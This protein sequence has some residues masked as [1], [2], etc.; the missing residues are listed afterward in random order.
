MAAGT[1]TDSDP[2]WYKDAIIYQLH[3]KTFFDGNDDGYGDFPG[4]VAKLD[5]IQELGV[6]CIWLLPFYPSPL[7]DDGYDIADYRG[8]HPVY[9]ERKDFRTFIREAHRRGIRVITELVV[10]HT[11]DQH[12]WFQAARHAPSGSIKRKYYVWSKTDKKF[13]NARIIFTDTEKSN[14]TWDPVANAFYWHR[15]F[16]HQPDLNFD[17]PH[18]RAAVVRIMRFW[19]DMGVDGLRL[20]AVPY[21]VE[22]EGTNCEN[23]P[24]T[25]EVVRQW[26][27]IIDE[28]Y[29][30]R[31]L[32]AEANQSPADVV[33]YFGSGDECHMAYHFPVMPRIFI[34]LH[35]E[36]RHPIT[37]IIEQTP[38]IPDICQWVIFLRNHDELSLE[39][40]TDAER[41]YMYTAYAQDPLMRIN[42]G[43]RRRL[44][45]LVQYSRR[46]IELLN[47]LLF[48]LPGTPVIYYGDEIGMGENV[49]LG[50]R[51][52]VRTP[53]QWNGDRNGGFSRALFAKLYSPP[54]MDPVTGYQTINVEEQSM[55]PS[56]L[57]HW[58]QTIIR[59]RR[60]YKV[61]GRGTIEFLKP[62]NRKVLAFYR[63]YQDQIVLVVANLS[64]YPQA[65]EL[66]L[67]SYCGVVP[68]E[69]FGLGEFP[70]IDQVP[71][72]ITLGAYSFYWFMLQPVCDV[73]HV[74]MQFKGRETAGQP[75]A[76]QTAPESPPFQPVYRVEPAGGWQSLFAGPFRQSLETEIL[77]PFIR[78]QSWFKTAAGAVESV[79]V[80][81]WFEVGESGINFVVLVQVHQDLYT[82][83]LS[84]ADGE[85]AE[86]ILTGKPGAVVARLSTSTT[87][88]TILYDAVENDDFCLSLLGTVEH[89]RTA[90]THAGKVMGTQ[91][92]VFGKSRGSD[93]ETPA[94]RR[95]RTEQSNSSVV[96]GN[97]L[98]LKL[99]R[100]LRPGTD[101]GYKVGRFLVEHTSFRGAPSVAGAIE[102]LFSESEEHYTLALLQEFIAGQGDGWTYSV[103]ELRR[104]FERA[105]AHMY[106]LDKLTREP[107]SIARMLEQEFAPEA[108]WL[109]GIYIKE[110]ATLG[111]RTGE[112]H[113]ALAAGTDDPDFATGTYSRAELNEFVDSLKRR[114][115][116]VMQTLQLGRTVE[117]Q[118]E[119]LAELFTLRARLLD[120]VE[121]ARGLQSKL[122]SSR[123]HGDFH[124]G[125][126]LRVAADF[127]ITGFTGQPVRTATALATRRTPIKDVS[128]MLRSLS[129]ATFA[130]LFVFTH[131]RSEELHR[132]IPWARLCQ[133]WL[134]VA[135]LQS[136]LA[137]TAGSEFLPAVREDF[138]LMLKALMIEKALREIEYELHNR[139]DWLRVPLYGLL[140]LVDSH[141]LD[142]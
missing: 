26:R 116:S 136:Y 51:N 28:H 39:M 131:S 94:V 82:L 4:L 66:D 125:R 87:G 32:L 118:G 109:L 31:V 88:T 7:R 130:S 85:E 86:E 108:H 16:H 128:D 104:F 81:D 64:R 72:T 48:S 40:V 27:K 52:S 70:R 111:V 102:Y 46:R 124:L 2:L 61:F 3:V 37:D 24:E 10:N 41:E 69:M 119:R 15:F 117:E 25:H 115:E 95:I 57:L 76:E 42:V 35:Q 137:T 19:L 34:A 8:V 36:D 45:P 67:S 50:D 6:N 93:L 78:A 141:A 71:Y 97:R 12:P 126:V 73:L 49:F 98:I 90:A 62:E 56:S 135:F 47:S 79:K 1:G 129:Y 22:R 11:S 113:A 43:I 103:D 133:V 23:L 65:A 105:S 114:V 21:L 80:V 13:K 83:A 121:A 139:P 96:L 127:V 17:N 110:V 74:P 29:T 122:P 132:F 14:W 44:A 20:D 30:D 106:L 91:T 112:L 18:V 140:E 33:Y 58:M 92:L 120:I 101:P 55:D 100:H 84:V 63:K 123:C 38:G 5:Y 107:L 75:A 89:S 9:G 60:Q 54:N 77:P 99:F 138:M 134:M 53:M 59:L 142:A 68:V